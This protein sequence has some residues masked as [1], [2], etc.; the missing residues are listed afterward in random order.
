MDATTAAILGT[1]IGAIAAIVSAG[2]T[3]IVASR[4]E[5]RRQADAKRT[6]DIEALRKAAASAFIEIFVIQHSMEW[7]TWYAKYS[8]DSVTEVMRGQ[9]ESEIHSAYPRLLGAL[10]MV[11]ALDLRTHEALRTI[12][13]RVY[14]TEERVALALLRADDQQSLI[15]LLPEV[16]KME[17]EFP[18]ELAR[19]MNIAEGSIGR[20]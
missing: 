19:V 10:A 15:D 20:L 16:N 11:A 9:Y 13:D 8:P 4:T 17:R 18:P 1:L 5:R 2:L 14:N 3:S 6:A 7:V 12:I